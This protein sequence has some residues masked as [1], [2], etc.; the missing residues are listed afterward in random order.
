M[1]ERSK[2]EIVRHYKR[3]LIR[4]AHDTQCRR[5]YDIAMEELG[6]EHANELKELARKEKIY[7]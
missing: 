5:A 1:A 3:I 7:Q 4:I 2:K 6:L